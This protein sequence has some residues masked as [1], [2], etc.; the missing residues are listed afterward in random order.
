L[1]NRSYHRCL[2]RLSATLCAILATSAVAAPEKSIWYTDEDPFDTESL[3]PPR[4]PSGY[5]DESAMDTCAETNLSAA[6]TLSETVNAALCNNPQTRE[7]WASARQQA[8]QLGIARSA[9]LPRIDNTLSGSLGA[10]TPPSIARDNPYTTL[11][12]SLVASYLLF[13]FGT[14]DAN[15]ENAR[16][17]LLAASATQNSIVQTILLNVVQAYFQVQAGIAALEAALEAE[18]AAE[19]SFKAA[20][21]RYKA[22]VATPA[23]KLQAQTAYAQATLTRITAQGTLQTAYGRLA[24]VMGLSANQPLTLA[25]SR[26][27]NVPD[28]IEEDIDTLITQAREQRPDLVATEAQ[29][30]AALASVDASRA[31]AKPTVTLSLSNNSQNG[32]D[33]NSN[34]AGTIGL[35]LNIPLFEGYAPSYRIRS[36]EAFAETVTAQRDRLRLQ[37]S[38]DVWSAFQDL[39]TAGQSVRAAEVLVASAEESARLNLGRYKAGVGNILDTIN[40]QSALASAMQQKIQSDLNWNIARAT[41]AQAVGALDNAMIQSFPQ[42][43]MTGTALTPERMP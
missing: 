34:N 4:I 10:N 1:Q 36:A 25:A 37:I 41:L 18:R 16:Q 43:A 12:N 15:L 14:R 42:P 5:L 31:A 21:A 23:D 7:A 17:L 32:S 22:G 3:T 27:V 9:Y 29:L 19:E 2:Q 26:P 20:E 24:N 6:L 8:A 38:L 28:T 11:N 40:A 13:D 30:K 35:N 33:L 39:I